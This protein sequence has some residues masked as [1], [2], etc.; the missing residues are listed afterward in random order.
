MI[1]EEKPKVDLYT[2]VFDGN[3][4]FSRTLFATHYTFKENPDSDYKEVFK[5]FSQS[6][7][8][9][10]RDY[11]DCLKNV[12][13]VRDLKSWRKSVD[14]IVP[15]ELES[16]SKDERQ[17]KANRSKNEDIDMKLAMNCFNDWLEFIEKDFKVPVLSCDG[18]EGDDLLYYVVK[19]EVEKGNKLLLFSSDGD[20]Q[21]L[22]SKDVYILKPMPSTT[23]DKLVMSKD[24]KELFHPSNNNE[25]L[26][27]IFS[28]GQKVADIL[29]NKFVVEQIITADPEQFLL[30]KSIYGD[31]K[32][33]IHPIFQWVINGMTYKPS[34]M[35]IKKA[36]GDSLDGVTF[37]N[38]TFENIYD[39]IFME[40]LIKSVIIN[41]PLGNDLK[42]AMKQFKANIKL[43]LDS[44][45]TPRQIIQTSVIG[46]DV[47]KPML[48]IK[49][50]KSDGK[51]VNLKPSVEYIDKILSKIDLNDDLMNL[52]LIKGIKFPPLFLN[53]YIEDLP[54]LRDLKHCM[55]IFV[56]N[57][58]ML[59][60]NS[61][62]IP[63]YVLENMDCSYNDKIGIICNLDEL[64]DIRLLLGKSPISDSIFDG[65][66]DIDDSVN[67]DNSSDLEADD[68]MN[69]VLGEL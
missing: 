26:F 8:K 60:L 64:S 4:F 51:Q 44:G 10:I 35:Y 41:S 19:K 61:V 50:Y 22:V 42:K 40:K 21:Q 59:H 20:I 67:V 32:D 63:S 7:S 16:L 14:M 2:F 49:T 39:D 24:M 1:F 33:N 38:I 13:F 6:F 47:I 48:N 15:Y 9:L 11:Q 58:A 17:Y 30:L 18:A 31:K 57:R 56:Q 52:K 37:D 65:L 43:L 66:D 54:L 28:S 62:S 46:N 55:K 45:L 68:I 29:V 12:I 69:L 23:P 3:Y 25:E 27:S 5:S 34:T 53:A 36:F